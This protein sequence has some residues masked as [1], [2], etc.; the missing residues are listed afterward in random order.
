[1]YDS[2]PGLGGLLVLFAVVV[3]FFCF[4]RKYPA[5]GRY[6]SEFYRILLHQAAM[7]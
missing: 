4:V 5:Q 1:M 6:T 2:G 7:V 3:G